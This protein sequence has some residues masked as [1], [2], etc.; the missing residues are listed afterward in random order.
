MPARATSAYVIGSGPNGL[1][2]AITLQRAGISTTVLEAQSSIG[3]GTRSAPLT[4]PGFVHDLCSAVHPMGVSSPAFLSFSLAQHGLEW[5]HPD[6][7]LAHPLDDGSAVILHRSIDETAQGLHQDSA[8]WRCA[9]APL[10]RHWSDLAAGMLGPLRFPRHPFLLSRFGLLAPWPASIA[11]R[12]LFRTDPARALFAGAA[13]HSVL[14]LE[15]PMSSA[16]GWAIILAAHGV[17]WPIAKG[18]SQAIAQALVSYLT[19]LGGKISSNVPVRSLNE[20][21]DADIIL[22]DVTPRQLL[23]LAAGRLPSSYAHKLQRFRYGPGVFKMDWA[24]DAPAPWKSP[25]CLRAATVHLGGTLDEIAASERAPWE[26]HLAKRPFVIFV[27][28]SLFDATRAPAG[29]H[30]AWAYCHVPNG[31][32]ADMSSAIE[33]QIERFA[34]GFRSHIL[35]RSVMNTADLERHNGN[36]QGGDISGGAQMLGQFFLRPTRSTYRTPIHGLYLC[37]ASTPPG[38][39]VHG[40]CGYYAAQCA[41]ADVK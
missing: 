1:T 39:G 20:L 6:A 13:A 21:A 35:A 33:A 34:P 32:T 23:A 9:V 25:D 4:L 36:L 10:A 2:A 41:L 29:K 17:G 8:R 40:M 14:P 3:G 5:I 12:T 19:S 22:C 31:S 15:W 30:T 7:P 18:G 26:G 27:Q 24:L 38:G 28:P 37:S 11:A 16:I